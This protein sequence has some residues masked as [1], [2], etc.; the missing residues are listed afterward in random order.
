MSTRADKRLVISVTM[1]PD[2]YL[3]VKTHCRDTDIPV[4]VWVRQVL[5]EELN[6]EGQQ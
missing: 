3:R 6:R 1:Q 5:V 4:S 2:L